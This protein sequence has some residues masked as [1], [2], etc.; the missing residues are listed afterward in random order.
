MRRLLQNHLH[1]FEAG[2]I[3]VFFVQTLRL[4][5]GQLYSQT[6]SSALVSVLDPSTVDF[7]RPGVVP[8][9]QL[10]SDLG[11]LTLMLAL[12][13]LLLF[14]GRVRWLFVL[15]AAMVAGGRLLLAMNTAVSTTAAASL[16]IG[17]GLLYIGLLV[18]QRAQTLP[19]FFVLGFGLD[20]LL[21]AFGN[22]LDPSW[23]PAYAP[24][25]IILSLAA[26]LL[27]LMRVLRYQ[28]ESP[29][30]GVSADYGLMPLWGGVSLGALLFLEI[31]LLALPNAIAGRSDQDYTTLVPLVAAATL[32]PLI[33]AVRTQA[34]S[35]ISVLDG[36]LRGWFWMLLI[37]LLVIVGTR[38]RGIVFLSAAS[39]II[40]QFTV[41]LLWWWLTRP[42]AARER[43]LSGLW[44]IVGM[45]VLSLLVVGD[46]FTYEYAFVRGLATPYDWLNTLIPALL[47][48][49]RGMGLALLL[50]AVFLATLPMTQIQRR[51]P[52]P[53]GPGWQNIAGLLTLVVISGWAALAA[54][55][56]LI[57]GVR[58]QPV[59]RVGT[60][61]I[62]DG[63][64][65]YYYPSLEDI[66]NTIELSGANVVLLQEVD[67]GRA[68]SY[69][70]DEALWLARRLGMDRRFFATNEGLEGLAVLSNIEIVFDEGTL[71]TST[72][73]QTGVQ[74]IQIRPDAGILTVYN[75]WLGLLLESP[76]GPTIEEQE[77]DQQRQLNEIFTIINNDHPNGNFNR[78]IVGGTF[79]NTPTSPLAQQM[80]A[81]SF[82]DPFAG[83]PAIQSYTLSRSN[84]QARVDYLWLYEP[85][86]Q[87]SRAGVMDSLA[88]DHRMAVIELP[89]ASPVS[90]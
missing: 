4:L 36:S 12:P 19:Y 21:R 69:G 71:L 33:P 3:G 23:T 88:S 44:L 74:R 6:A 2:L 24:L 25:F 86:L 11:F 13:L 31:T 68:T 82:R 14:L 84:L 50:L 66:A 76:N 54:R 61:N 87:E 32:L 28:A 78:L 70:V 18:R 8:P 40:A 83:Q 15:A 53:D 51:I 41:S 62:H 27:V 55:P 49:F 43:N 39:L 79:N 89:I 57:L 52:W 26:F 63:Y 34:R 9:G 73:K 60:Y 10:S 67:V 59:I 45:L 29:E 16:V 5:I 1:I 58:D 20:Q 7:S 64:S 65:E 81:A 37:M 80:R 75:T 46:I 77:Q 85:R 72:G 17:G 22:T 35:F 42:Q 90:G 38:V 48:G 30:S 56:P 47:R